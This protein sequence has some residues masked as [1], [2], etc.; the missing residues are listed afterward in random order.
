MGTTF[1]IQDLPLK[2]KTRSA[3]G[4]LLLSRFPPH[5]TPPR[6]VLDQGRKLQAQLARLHRDLERRRVNQKVLDKIREYER[7]L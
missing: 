4:A 6:A 2:T 7:S 3:V 1:A 5:P